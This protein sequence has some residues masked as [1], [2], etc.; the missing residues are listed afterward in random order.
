MSFLKGL[1]REDA[2]PTTGELRSVLSAM[3]RERTS[4]DAMVQ[5]AEAASAELRAAQAGDSVTLATSLGDRIAALETQLRAVESLAPAL[6]RAA[7]R[8]GGFEDAWDKTEQRLAELEQR[9]A[10]VS[11]NVGL[12]RDLGDR[13]PE[14]QHQVGVLRALVE[15]TTQK[16][17]AFEQQRDQIDRA[18][19]QVGQI[20][21]VLQQL[22]TGFRRQDELLSSL[23]DLE[24]R[25]ADTEA[26]HRRVALET[27]GLTGRH[28]AMTDE[29]ERAQ[30]V[31]EKVRGSLEQGAALVDHEHRSL[32]ALTQ[33]VEEIREAVKDCEARLGS[34]NATSRHIVGLEGQAQHLFAEVSRLSGEFRQLS[35]RAERSR[36]LQAE[37]ARLEQLL[38]GVQ[39]RVQKI[40]DARPSV[41]TAIQDLAVLRGSQE[42]LREALEQVGHAQQELGRFR[43][44]QVEMQAWL[45]RNDGATRAMQAQVERV[46]DRVETVASQVG[47]AERRMG[48]VSEALDHLQERAGEFSGLGE[49][50]RSLGEDLAQREA[51]MERAVGQLARTTELRREAVETAERLEDVSRSLGGALSDAEVRSVELDRLATE[52]AER[53]GALGLVQDQLRQF[54]ERLTSWQTSEREMTRAVEAVLERQQA[55]DH[56]QQGVR[57]VY[58][59]AERTM[60]EART[61]TEARREVEATARLLA[62][63]REQLGDTST[64]LEDLERRK[65]QVEKAEHRLAR[66]EALA[67]DLRASLESLHTQRAVIDQALEKAAGLGNQMR[68]AETVL[69]ALREER[70]VADRVRAAVTALRE[71]DAS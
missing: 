6:D 29:S 69:E 58:A 54:D 52:L 23:R 13:V 34:L 14:A 41:E 9:A 27:E 47:D 4:L 25:L 56:L 30:E 59:L 46:G 19:G 7:T 40:E 33:R 64:A 55:V 15:Q 11:E 10:R 8:L 17:A 18:S 44:T 38:A 3:Q 20:H 65:A 68:Q 36:G 61:I 26:A 71:E 48:T 24:T 5:R 16:L 39:L 63:T 51:G 22:D 67:L 43:E 42:T 31:L 50:I 12:F 49:R 1:K 57:D 70:T 45:A 21:G 62:E 28:K 2:G 53:A 60:A 37:S 32:D 66:A 35:E